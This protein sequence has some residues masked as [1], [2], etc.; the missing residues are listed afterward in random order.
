MIVHPQLQNETYA[1]PAPMAE[2]PASSIWFD[3]RFN[4]VRD[5]FWLQNKQSHAL[6]MSRFPAEQFLC[7]KIAAPYTDR[8]NAHTS[9]NH[10]SKQHQHRQSG[11]YPGAAIA[12]PHF[13]CKSY[14]KNSTIAPISDSRKSRVQDDHVLVQI[15]KF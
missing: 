2:A 4:S 7:K 12:T 9:E 14:K 3:T 5:V 6:I 11:F 15:A 10:R 1:R 13:G 8:S